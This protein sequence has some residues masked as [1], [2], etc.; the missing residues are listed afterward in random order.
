[1]V[2]RRIPPTPHNF[3]VWYA[4]A[5][6]STPSLTRAIDILDSNRVDYTAERNMELY[7][8]LLGPSRE[9]E[10]IREAGDRISAA[11]AVVLSL[12]QKAGA[13]TKR[14]GEAM[15]AEYLIRRL[16]PRTSSAGQTQTE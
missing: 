15:V 3:A 14:Y 7:E 4:Y 8:Q 2:A 9:A 11:A 13:G 16:A 12:V 5:S 1:M 10:Q 6:G